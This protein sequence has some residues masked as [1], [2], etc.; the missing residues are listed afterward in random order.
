MKTAIR[1]E[2]P[3]HRKRGKVIGATRFAL[4]V[5]ILTLCFPVWAQQP[6]K[7]PR[8]GFLGTASPSVA[9]ARLDAFRRGLRELGYVDGSN[10]VIEQ[11]FAEGKLDRVKELADELAR[12]PVNVIVTVGPAATLPG[13]LLSDFDRARLRANVKR[14][15][16][17][18]KGVAGA[19]PIPGRA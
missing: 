3:G 10:I 18:R 5:A 6:Q 9:A 8:I 2:A 15:G 12:L 4:G 1:R 14:V 16:T 13:G 7:V 11:R 17:C 19:A